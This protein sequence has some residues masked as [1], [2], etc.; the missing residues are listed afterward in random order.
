MVNRILSLL[1][2]SNFIEISVLISPSNTWYIVWS[3]I[4][5]FWSAILQWDV[6]KQC[7]CYEFAKF[8]RSWS[9]AHITPPPGHQ[10]ANGKAESAVKSVEN[11]LKRTSPDDTD[12]YLALLK[13]RSMVSWIAA[14]RKLFLVEIF[15]PSGLWFRNRMLNSMCINIASGNA[16]LSSAMINTQSLLVNCK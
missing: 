13:M 9:V 8:T 11:M 3:A 15:A 12:Q 5:I 16:K 10:S 14:L 1:I 6:A 7:V 2:I 4:Y